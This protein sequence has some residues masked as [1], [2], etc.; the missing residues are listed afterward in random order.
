MVIRLKN[1]RYMI[2]LLFW[3]VNYKIVNNIYGT[4]K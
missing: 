1:N 4:R 3:F 2:K